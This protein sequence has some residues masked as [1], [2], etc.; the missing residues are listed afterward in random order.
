ME[1]SETQGRGE[2]R[3]FTDISLYFTDTSSR[4]REIKERINKWDYIKLK[5]F[6]QQKKTS[7]K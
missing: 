2:C 7:A 3:D 1:E 6:A 4:E 5:S